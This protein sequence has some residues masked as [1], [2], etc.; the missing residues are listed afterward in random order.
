MKNLLQTH[1]I[2]HEY[3]DFLHR[4]TDINHITYQPCNLNGGFVSFYFRVLLEN[5]R[6]LVELQKRSFSPEERGATS[7]Y[8]SFHNLT[9]VCFYIFQTLAS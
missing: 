4:Y 5:V 3:V 2:T 7:F 1:D 9:D 6:E 8:E